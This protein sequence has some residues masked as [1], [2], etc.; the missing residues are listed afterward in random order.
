M[1]PPRSLPYRVVDVFTETRFGGNPLAVVLDADA[2]TTDE[3]QIIAREFGF[4][5]TSFVLS[6]ENPAY[7]AKVRIFTPTLEMPFAGHPNVGT[8]YVLASERDP[9]P[10][11]MVFEEKAGLVEVV[12]TARDGEVTATTIRAPEPL[13]EGPEIAV[14][15]AAAALSL[16][17]SEV[18]TARHPPQIASVGAPFLFV[19]LTSRSALRQAHPNPQVIADTLAGI[20]S[21]P[22]AIYAYTRDTGPEDGQVDWTARMF[23]PADGIAEDPA[24]GS[25]AGA[26]GAIFHRLGP[27]PRDGDTYLVAQGVDMGR[28]SHLWIKADGE[29][30]TIGGATQ[31]VM[32]GVLTV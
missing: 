9:I 3:M 26:M 7:D 28:P 21:G 19:E 1:R 5:E 15:A 12:V 32:S 23:A 18:T 17:P 10:E 6:P 4:S 16:P 30:T 14:D 20:A 22:D 13:S 8:A 11:R 27:A 31:P 29:A 25:A 2:L 24:T